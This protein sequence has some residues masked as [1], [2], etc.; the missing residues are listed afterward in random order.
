M[1]DSDACSSFGSSRITV[2]TWA[3]LNELVILSYRKWTGSQFRTQEKQLPDR[4]WKNEH[5]VWKFPIAGFEKWRLGR[6][7]FSYSTGSIR[8]R[9]R[10]NPWSTPKCRK[11][12]VLKRNYTC[13]EKELKLAESDVRTMNVSINST[14][15]PGRCRPLVQNGEFRLQ[16]PPGI[17]PEAAWSA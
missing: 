13:Q 3:G 4:L 6:N 15:L 2:K 9:T 17:Y 7:L 14:P 16:V 1:D 8:K 11:A 10:L 12:F 5:S